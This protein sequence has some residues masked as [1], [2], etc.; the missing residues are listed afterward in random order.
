VPF[1]DIAQ[2]SYVWISASVWV[3]PT[4]SCTLNNSCIIITAQHKDKNYCY[5]TKE[6]KQL[7]LK[8]HEWNYVTL[9]YI[10]PEVRKKTDVIQSYIWL[11]GKNPIYIDDFRIDVF[12]PKKD[13]YQLP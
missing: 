2:K 7:N 9:D 3:Y 13:N 11:M 8:L 6:F 1:K 10:T 4:D 5:R 12:E